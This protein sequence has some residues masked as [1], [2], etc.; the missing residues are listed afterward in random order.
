MGVLLAALCLPGFAKVQFDIMAMTGYSEVNFP[1]ADHPPSGSYLS[2]GTHAFGGL[3]HNPTDSGIN[4]LVRLATK[5]RT[6]GDGGVE[7][8]IAW[9]KYRDTG[10]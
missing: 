10:Y 8:R 3:I 6:D 7:Q 4:L 5:N 2:S 9:A 1:S